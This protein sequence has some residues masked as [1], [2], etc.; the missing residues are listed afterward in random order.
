MNRYRM[1]KFDDLENQTIVDSVTGSTIGFRYFPKDIAEDITRMM[2]KAFAY[3]YKNAPRVMNQILRENSA[4]RIVKL[5][6]PIR[7]QMPGTH[8]DVIEGAKSAYRA[9]VTEAFSKAKEKYFM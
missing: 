3:G 8:K 7:F 2:N 9:G 4:E 1:E 6:L 5:G